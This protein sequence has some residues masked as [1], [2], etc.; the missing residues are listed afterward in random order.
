MTEQE[1]E[2]KAVARRVARDPER[3]GY[4]PGLTV[5]QIAQAIREEIEGLKARIL[6]AV[7]EPLP[8]L[9]RE[10]IERIKLVLRAH[11]FSWQRDTAEA[12]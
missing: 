4:L 2:I 7:G 8:V 12:R 3:F 6:E 10:T 5:G 9:D 1:I 11:R